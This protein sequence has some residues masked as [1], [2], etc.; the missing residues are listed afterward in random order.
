MPTKNSLTRR[1]AVKCAALSALAFPF[2][3]TIA[4]S[5]A[6][7]SAPVPPRPATRDRT[8]G[9]KLGVASISL[10][11][12]PVAAVAAALQQLEIGYVSIFRTHAAFEKGT[13]E[14]CRTAA[15]VFR[16]AGIAVATTSVVNLINDEVAVRRAFDNVRAAGLSLMTC[17]PVP[18]ALPLVERFAKEYDIRLAI[19]NHGPEDAV[20]PGPEEIFKL[21]QRYD[22]RIGLSLDVGHTMR[23]KADPAQA[24]RNCAARIYD[25]HLKDSLALPGALKDIPT[26][27]GRGQMD[28]RAILAALIEI[29]Y[30]GVVAFE[31]ERLGVNPL[32]GLAESVGYVRGVLAS[33]PA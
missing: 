23:T 18:E 29:K 1:D 33:L 9:I 26:E 15:E 4:T 10:Q 25:V 2:L 5:Q 13:P 6:A 22:A 32:I 31:Y 20:Y 12:L 17:R 11:A 19:H 28:I 16:A 21:I 14:E 8:R 7:E 3:G 30:S 24:I 27:V